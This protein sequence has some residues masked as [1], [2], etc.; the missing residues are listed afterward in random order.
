MIELLT[1]ANHF[2]N[3]NCADGKTPSYDSQK[4]QSEVRDLR[5]SAAVRNRA[6]LAF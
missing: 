4:Y 2:D 3:L 1:H 5:L 6:F